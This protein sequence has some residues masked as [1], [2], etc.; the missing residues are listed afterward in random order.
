MPGKNATGRWDQRLSSTAAGTIVLA[1]MDTSAV[2]NPKCFQRAYICELL[3]HPDHLK[4]QYPRPHTAGELEIQQLGMTSGPRM[5]PERGLLQ[6]DTVV[7]RP[8]LIAGQ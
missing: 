5:K 1:T 6:T 4:P 2:R 3:P 8:L 7:L